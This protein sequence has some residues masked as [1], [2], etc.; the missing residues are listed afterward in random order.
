MIN[1]KTNGGSLIIDIMIATSLSLFFIMI[2]T[3]SS[4]SAQSIFQKAKEKN[5]LLK[6]YNSSESSVR[7]YGNNFIE[8]DYSSS[9]VSFVGVGFPGYVDT[10]FDTDQTYNP[11][12]FPVGGSAICSVNFTDHRLL[13]SYEYLHHNDLSL[14]AFSSFN[15]I[16]INLPID[17]T[18]PLTHIEVRNNIAYVSANSAKQ[19]DPDIL[20]FDINDSDNV[21]QLSSLNTGPGISDIVLVG[22]R[23]YAA[24]PSTVGQ[25]QVI[26]LDSLANP[27][28]E[29]HFRLDLP[30]ATATPALGS[31]IA[32]KDNKIFLGTEKWD[33]DEFNIIDVSDFVLSRKIGGLE[34]DS[35]IN[36]ILINEKTAYIA[37]A[38]HNQLSI[39][40][41]QDSARPTLDTAFSP[42]GWQRQDGK[43]ISFF[44]KNLDFGRTS[45]G[46]DLPNDHE[47]FSWAS[48]S[49]NFQNYISN[50]IPGGIYGIIRDRSFIYLATRQL[51]KEF[52]VIDAIS[53]T[54]F[55]LPIAPQTMTCDG[56]SVYILANR[57]PFIYKITYSII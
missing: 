4:M 42:A 33:G 38:N 54:Y 48:T 25:L 43:S 36:N 31:A 17:P 34:I 14:F 52:Q 9:S 46:F 27:V 47:L 57:A 6:N 10:I 30:Y 55:S 28:L 3:E 29:N 44:E 41:F 50:N 22:K 51:D 8:R 21:R 5:D 12:S 40:D 53:S 35:K 37:S 7:L 19:A 24:V 23:I 16:P 45:G 49:N 13:G 11:I 20:I 32:Y 18:L 2:V 1:N 15:I 26:R 56:D 39:V